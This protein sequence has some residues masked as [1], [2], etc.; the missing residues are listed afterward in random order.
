MGRLLVVAPG[1][2]VG[3]A[4]LL[5]GAPIARGSRGLD[6]AVLWACAAMDV[7]LLALFVAGAGFVW[8]V[9]S[10]NLKLLLLPA[11]EGPVCP[12]RLRDLAAAVLEQGCALA[13]A[14]TASA[15]WGSARFSCSAVRFTSALGFAP[16]RSAPWSWAPTAV[17]LHGAASLLV[18]YAAEPSALSWANVVAS[19]PR[20]PAA[21]V[22]GQRAWWEPA[23]WF[24]TA[25]LL[26]IV[27]VGPVCEELLF[28]A[29][30]F[31]CL[32]HRTHDLRAS[33][34]AS[35]ALFSLAH[36]FNALS[37]RHALS[38][39]LHQVCFAAVVGTFYAAA[40]A[41]SGRLHHV[42][43]L[44]SLNNV[45]ALPM[46]T[47]SNP[48]VLVSLLRWCAVAFYALLARRELLACDGGGLA[49]RGW[50]EGAGGCGAQPAAGARVGDGR[51]AERGNEE[52]R[53]R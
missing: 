1:L 45:A 29:G 41:R 19:A 50:H 25:G 9:V 44:H 48:S 49:A 28:R 53:Q 12:L 52:G 46:H 34:V 22:C 24:D 30:V 14:A 20:A 37:G 7:F 5:D 35:A 42:V 51:I 36:A 6:R 21:D 39:A 26:Q 2:A 27:L 3:V 31:L 8:H 33:A 23:P 10:S 16:D 32:L 47:A 13:F 38:Y 40:L 17:A 11:Q 15:M 4:Q 43:L 18:L